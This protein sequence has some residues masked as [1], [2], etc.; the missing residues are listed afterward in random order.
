M[1]SFSLC[2]YAVCLVL[3]CFVPHSNLIFQHTSSKLCHNNSYVTEGALLISSHLST[4]TAPIK[5]HAVSIKSAN[6][7][8]VE[9]VESTYYVELKHA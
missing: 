2:V 5:S 4:K 9:T 8:G 3:G 7:L 1:Q 6:C